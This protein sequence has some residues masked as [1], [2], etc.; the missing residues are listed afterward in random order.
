MV[1]GENFKIK[2]YAWTQ[3]QPRRQANSNAGTPYICGGTKGPDGL[4]VWSGQ[5]YLDNQRLLKSEKFF[6][7]VLNEFLEAGTIQYLTLGLLK[8]VSHQSRRIFSD[9]ALTQWSKKSSFQ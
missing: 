1:R 7:Q 2:G 4:L 5:V 6:A 8:I 9:A 3:I